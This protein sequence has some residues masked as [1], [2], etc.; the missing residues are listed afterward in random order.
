[1][2]AR[3]KDLHYWERLYIIV[4]VPR[5]GI[6][7]SESVGQGFHCGSLGRSLWFQVSTPI[8]GQSFQHPI[9]KQ[10]GTVDSSI[11]IVGKMTFN[12]ILTKSIE[13]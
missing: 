1:M 13:F 9:K 3:F 7:K 2:Y 8:A 12:N 6:K 5:A 10:I 4:S 11:L